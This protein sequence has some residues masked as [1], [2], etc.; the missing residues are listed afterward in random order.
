LTALDTG[1]FPALVELLTVYH[2]DIAGGYWN[3]PVKS[4]QVEVIE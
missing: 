2:I 4:M 3:L 1:G